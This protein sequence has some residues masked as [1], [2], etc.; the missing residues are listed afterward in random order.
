MLIAD[1]LELIIWKQPHMRKRELQLYKYAAVWFLIYQY[2]NILNS[3]GK[4][5]L[6]HNSL[7]AT[8]LEDRYQLVDCVVALLEI[9]SVVHER[10]QNVSKALSESQVMTL[11]SQQYSSAYVSDQGTFCTTGHKPNPYWTRFWVS[12]FLHAEIP[13]AYCR[14]C[15]TLY[16]RC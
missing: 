11:R 2:K 3:N 15:S 12:E 7:H 9:R 1:G 5:S 16:I 4:S 14:R 6:T 10:Q 13:N 8:S